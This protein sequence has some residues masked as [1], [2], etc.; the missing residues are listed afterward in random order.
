MKKENPNLPPDIAVCF[1]TDGRSLLA[2]SFASDGA[3]E[4]FEFPVSGPLYPA[5]ASWRSTLGHRT[6]LQT[7]FRFVPLLFTEQTRVASLP[8]EVLALSDSELTVWLIDA[9]QKGLLG[10]D[11]L[12]IFESTLEKSLYDYARLPNGDI[13]LTEVPRE[14]LYESLKRL[15]QAEPLDSADLARLTRNMPEDAQPLLIH[16][17]ETRL[18]AIA[19]YVVTE[20][21]EY[22]DALGQEETVAFFAFTPEGCAFALWNPL[23]TFYAEFGEWFNLN[24]DEAEIPPGMDRA[25]FLSNLYLDAVYN[26]LHEQFYRHVEPEDETKKRIEIKRVFWSASDGLDKH[27]EPLVAEFSQSADFNCLPIAAASMEEAVV[28]GLLLGYDEEAERLV[29]S[30]NLANDLSVQNS[31]IN[32]EKQNRQAERMSAK[33]RIAFACLILPIVIA[34]GAVIGLFLNNQRI[35]A[36]LAWRESK[37][38]AEQNR[39]KPILQARAEYEKTLKWYEDVLRQI[40]ALRQKQTSS[41][42]FAARLDPLYP[43]TGAFYISDMKLSPG[44]AFELK[45]FTRDEKQVSDFLRALEF[46]QD[47]KEAR[48]FTG[49]QLEFKQGSLVSGAVAQAA[50]GNGISGNL[51][52]GV[53]GF[54][55][56]GGY[57]P[58]SVLKAQQQAPATPQAPSAASPSGNPP[59]QNKPSSPAAANTSS[60]AVKQ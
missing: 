6:D 34:F 48:Y 18:R 43:S 5:L 33:R 40:I 27:L 39:L 38:V 14:R 35:S 30:I 60:E 42:S 41:L 57:G 9:A 12:Q 19:R 2:A 49:L 28:R 52:P 4:A 55:L 46:A 50:S 44:G 53:S 45:G 17:A 24:F 25:E 23:M 13:S 58:A 59:A 15:L 32:A 10:E 22:F 26:F 56:K 3:I 8:D 21:A 16:A 47:D 11:G 1:K 20:Q 29:P 31:E 36:S 51:A 7:V 37:A 54:V